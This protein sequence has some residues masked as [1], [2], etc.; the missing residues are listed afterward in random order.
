MERTAAVGAGG[1]LQVKPTLRGQATMDFPHRVNRVAEMF[2]GVGRLEHI[3]I[4]DAK[5]RTP[6]EFDG[7]RITVEF[8]EP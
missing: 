4:T 5:V 2:E 8:G 7:D 1:G 3:H 6:V